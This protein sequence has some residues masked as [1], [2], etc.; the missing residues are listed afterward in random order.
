VRRFHLKAAASA[1]TVAAL[2]LVAAGAGGGAQKAPNRQ[3]QGN[4]VFLS[5]QLNTVPEAESMRK[6]ILRGY[7]GEVDF[8]NTTADNVSARMRAEGRAG[9]GTVSLVGDVDVNFIFYQDVLSNLSSTVRQVRSARIP[10]R[11]LT[12][13]KLGTRRQLVIPWMQATYIMVANRSALRYLPRGA[14]LNN[15]SYAQL[16]QWG[17]NIARGTGRPRIGFP[18]GPTGLMLRFLH[19]FLLPSYSGGVLTTW[20]SPASVRAWQLTRNLWRYVHPQSLQYNNMSEPLLSGEVLVAWDH[21]ARLRNALQTRP[22]EFVTF[23][24][25]RGPK[26]RAYLPVVAGVAIPKT[27]PNRAGATR[28][29]RYLLSLNAQ[30]RT[31]GSVGFF[32]VRGGRLSQQLGPGLLKMVATV[33][34]Q[35]K[36]KNVIV[37]GLPIGLGTQSSNFTRVFVETFVRIAVRGE[38]VN[39]V[40]ADQA[41]ALQNIMD[42]V[43]AP[44]FKPDPPSRG[45]CRV[46]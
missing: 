1:T 41:R 21:V 27:A 28:L 29:I 15:L 37:S 11:L 20:R 26:G 46:R 8:V 44:C 32:P 24:V 10:K 39:R 42:Q 36:A 14:K 18:V 19:G 3:Q 2:A 33:R 31:L 17:R 43:N 35:Q 34:R 13:G 7:P 9:R 40:L 6:L 22:N 25:P 30:A 38:N 16:L 12:L 23:P 5:S 4:V 45:T